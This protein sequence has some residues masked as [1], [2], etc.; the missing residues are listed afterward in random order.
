MRAK[1][2][3]DDFPLG[4]MRYLVVDMDHDPRGEAV[5]DHKS[6]EVSPETCAFS[7]DCSLNSLLPICLAQ[8]V[9]NYNAALKSK[10]EERKRAKR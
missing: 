4:Q 2:K 1:I 8:E 3:K 7:L 6:L 5:I 9:E 10:Q